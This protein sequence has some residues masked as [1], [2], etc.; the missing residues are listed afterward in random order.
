MYS[1]A[2]QDNQRRRGRRTRAGLMATA[3]VGL[4]LATAACSDD[5]SSP[6]VASAGSASPT[7]SSASRSASASAL[8]YAQCMRAHGIRDFPDPDSNGGLSLDAAQGSD[9]NPNNPQFKAADTACKS[10]LPQGQATPPPGAKDANLT[11]ARCMRAHGISDFP[12]PNADGTLKI[13]PKPGSNLDPTN[14]QFKTAHE[15][16]KHYMP[17]G[18]KGG[19]LSSNGP[20]GGS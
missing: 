4:A 13:E 15:A 12:D 17:G 6:R 8:A 20:G 9:L 3:I 19:S 11:Y 14:P 16:C 7:G 1:D 5:S 18:G 2:T 10:L